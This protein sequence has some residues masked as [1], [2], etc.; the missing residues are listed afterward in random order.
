M[1]LEE[2]LP[3]PVKSTEVDLA[4]ILTRFSPILQEYYDSFQHLK[5]E[6]DKEKILA[7][8]IKLGRGE[9]HVY[10]GGETLEMERIASEYTYLIKKG[11]IK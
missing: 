6:T 9:F 5:P 1:A 8:Q 7:L 10:G 2:K 11:L 3:E 4:E